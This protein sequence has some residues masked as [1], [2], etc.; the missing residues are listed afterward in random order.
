MITAHLAPLGQGCQ[1]VTSH[2]PSAYVPTV[3]HIL[4]Q[5]WNG[6]TV[7]ENL[8]TIC[9][10]THTAVHRLIDNYVRAGGDPGWDV[11]QHFSAYQRDLALRAWEQ[12]PDVPTIT[13][14]AHP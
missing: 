3:H 12:R 9:P 5:S 7:P 2:S 13:S 4:P 8:A 6:Q 14:V 11:R 1:C 10:N